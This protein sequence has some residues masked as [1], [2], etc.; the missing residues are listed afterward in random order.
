MINVKDLGVVGDGKTDDTQAIQDAINYVGEL[1]GGML[2]FPPGTYV[3]NPANDRNITLTSNLTLKGAGDSS[4]IKVADDAGDYFTIFGH[5]GGVRPDML[6]NIIIEDLKIDQNPEGNTTCDVSKHNPN[7]NH[8]QHVFSFYNFENVR[9]RSVSF[10][11]TTSMNTI[12]LND[13]TARFASVKDCYFN[14]VRGKTTDP[15]YDNSAIYFQ[16]FEHV[17]T[18]NHFTTEVGHG[19]GAIETHTGI[20]VIANNT[21]RNYLVGVH[22]QHAEYEHAN[23]N[24]HGNTIVDAGRGILL[25]GHKEVPLKN[26]NIS[27]N[28]IKVNNLARN[29]LPIGGIVAAANGHNSDVYNLNISGNTVEFDEET[30]PRD[31]SL[32]YIAGISLDNRF[33]TK[34]NVNISGNNILNSP[35][36]G[37]SVGNYNGTGSLEN[38]VIQGNTITNAGH[39]PYGEDRRKVFIEVRGLAHNILVANNALLET[40]ETGRAYAAIRSTAIADGSDCVSVAGNVVKSIQELRVEN[41]ERETIK[42]G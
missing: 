37:I 2:Y 29:V 11:P 4:V 1:G 32:T 12:T 6:R 9:I 28:L 19:I 26:V 13:K 27:N 42:N 18:G 7:P 34:Q 25:W 41:F 5:R 24:I 16:C 35:S 17:A 22:V 15:N 38:T 3:V 14:F 23:M 20:S 39:A 8:R 31:V 30:E 36:F 40:H 33:Q 21:I 10:D